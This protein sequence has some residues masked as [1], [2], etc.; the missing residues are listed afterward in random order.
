[1]SFLPR[2]ATRDVEHGQ[3]ARKRDRIKDR[4]NANHM[5]TRMNDLDRDSEGKREAYRQERR[6]VLIAAAMAI[7]VAGIALRNRPRP[8]GNS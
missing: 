4:R 6:A 3:N 8:A 7:T 1:M 2:G 5:P